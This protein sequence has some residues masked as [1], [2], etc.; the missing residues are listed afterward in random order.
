M[1]IVQR[2]GRV[3]RLGSRHDT[4]TSAVFIPEKELEDILGLLNKLE[5]KIQKIA[6]TVGI[7]AT[8]L[9]ER[10]KPKNLLGG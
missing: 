9:G 2:A 3:D 5:M 7:E 1:I 6:D 4:V 8:I 10:E